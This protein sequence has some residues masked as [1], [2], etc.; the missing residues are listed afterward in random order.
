MPYCM[1]ALLHGCLINDEENVMLNFGK[2]V[3]LILGFCVIS[4]YAAGDKLKKP[5]V[6]LDFEDLSRNELL[7][8]Q[9]ADLGVVFAGT[10]EG[11]LTAGLIGIAGDF[12]HQYYGNSE[13]NF[14]QIGV[15]ILTIKFIDPITQEPSAVRNV[16]FN[17]GD[18]VPDIEAFGVTAFGPNGTVVESHIVHLFEE[19]A[20]I[21]LS[22]GE[23]EE[24][25]IFGIT[26]CLGC[27]S[28][29][30]IDDF[31]FSY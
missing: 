16:T 3:I 19:G 23:I 30:V 12:G 4:A 21:E 15:G 13:P 18:G 24:I 9:Y 5:S 10:F 17:A 8:D 6:L 25:R 28:G 1:D 22:G 2:V 31:T 27:G 29:F 20:I 7:T 11:N 14:V 26:G